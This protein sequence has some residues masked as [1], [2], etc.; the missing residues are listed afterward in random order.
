MIRAY[1]WSVE[2]DAYR[3]LVGLPKRKRRRLEQ[4]IESL[5]KRPFQEPLIVEQDADG[6]HLAVAA[7]DDC[8]ITYH[9]DHAVRRIRI[10]EICFLS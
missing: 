6:Q 9:A 2:G 10:T 7:V 5:V 3:F 4:A 1:T 8:V